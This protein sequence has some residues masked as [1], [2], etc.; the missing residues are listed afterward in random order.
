L[1]RAAG[2]GSITAALAPADHAAVLEHLG[3]IPEANGLEGLRFRSDPRIT[4]G[5]C[6]LTTEAGCFDGRI[7][8]QMERIEAALRKREPEF[9]EEARRLP[10]GPRP[11]EGAA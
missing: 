7:E 2:A 1:Q 5:G 4:P 11:E 3:S 6:H 8:T 10:A 9:H